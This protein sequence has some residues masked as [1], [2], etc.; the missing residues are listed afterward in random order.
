MIGE[1][2]GRCRW[3]ILAASHEEDGDDSEALKAS[4]LVG[5]VVDNK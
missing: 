4:R 5:L 2:G 1:D 3:R